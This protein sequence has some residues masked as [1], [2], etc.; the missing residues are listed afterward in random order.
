MI[1]RLLHSDQPVGVGLSYS[2]AV[3]G[4]VNPSYS[5]STIVLPETHCPDYAQPFD[6]C[7][8]YSE[9]NVL[10]TA[11]STQG[12][13]PNVWKVCCALHRVMPYSSVQL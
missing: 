5:G 12:A 2:K 4:Y 10:K 8:T 1:L 7:G 9:P 6:T 11:N 13:A 3:P